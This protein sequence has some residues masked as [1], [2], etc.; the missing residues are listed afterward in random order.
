L[1]VAKAAISVEAEKFIFL[2]SIGVH[3]SSSSPQAPFSEASPYDPQNYYALTK[4]R[5]EMALSELFA[6]SRTSLI[7][8]RPPLVYGPRLLGNLASL[9]RLLDL[10]IP[11]PFASVNNHRSLI[12]VFNL[13]DLIK[14]LSL[15]SELP[16]AAFVAADCELIST[17]DLLS[18]IAYARHKRFSNYSIPHS[19]FQALSLMPY[20]GVKVN[21]LTSSLC[22]DSRHVRLLT[23]WKQ[24][25]PQLDGL[26]R[27]FDVPN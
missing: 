13:V 27:A 19:V 12:S 15:C 11:L 3:G 18:I 21:Q 1:K 2:S 20:V 6:G 14:H 9:V 7:I 4:V 5:A 23:G 17:P 10:E 25:L 8:I 26:L 24:P 16:S 22:V